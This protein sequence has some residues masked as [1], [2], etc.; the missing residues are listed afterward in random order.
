MVAADALALGALREAA[1]SLPTAL[2]F[3]REWSQY[4][5][6]LNIGGGAAAHGSLD[7]NVGGGRECVHWVRDGPEDA[8]TDGGCGAVKELISCQL[9][10]GYLGTYVGK[11][12][13]YQG[14][15]VDWRGP[16][17]DVWMHKMRQQKSSF[18]ILPVSLEMFRRHLGG[19]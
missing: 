7:V 11:D 17:W 12:Q 15:G 18:S 8:T 2:L 5:R 13:F 1:T 10:N 6:C 16:I 19:D 3:S 14:D 9:D 4:G